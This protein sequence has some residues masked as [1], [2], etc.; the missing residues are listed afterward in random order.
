[1]ANVPTASRGPMDE[2]TL[3]SIVGR[4][5]RQAVDWLNGEIGADRETALDYYYGEPFGD[6]Q[7]GRSAVVSTDVQD[8]IE[9]IMPSMMEIFGGSQEVCSFDPRG[10]EDEEVASQA[11]AYVNYVW[12]S[13]NNGWS[14]IHDWIK[15]SL[16]QKNGVIK[17]YW[18]DTPE[19]KRETMVD[20][21]SLR[22]MELAEDDDIEILEVEQKQAPEELAMYIPDGLL[23]D[24][25]VK[26]LEQ[27]GRV[28]VEGLPPEEFLISRRTTDL[29][30]A[31]FLAHK[32]KKTRSDLLE[33]GFSR[34][35]VESIP[36]WDDHEYNEE[37]QARFGDEEF[38]DGEDTLDWASQEVWLYDCYMR[39]DHDGDGIT[40]MRN[41]L[42]A[43]SQY[44]I[45]SNEEVDEHPFCAITPVKMPHKFFGRS[46]ADLTVDIQK[47]KS[48][49][50]RQLLD[51]MYLTNNAR[52]GVSNKVDLDDFLTNRPGGGV[53]VD[54]DAPDV[55]GHIAPIVTQPLG[56]QALPL[57]DYWD[58][59]REV[60][61]GVTRYNQGMDAQALNKTASGINQI[62]GQAAKR[63]LLIARTFAETGFRP[64]M[65]KT[66]KLLVNHQDRERVI[67]LKNK[68]VPMDPRSWNADMDATINV[69]LGHGTKES[70]QVADQIILQLMEKVIQL[71]GGVQGPFVKPGNVHAVLKRVAVNNGYP[72]P[73]LVWSDPTDPENQPPPPQPN[74][75]VQIEQAKIQLEGQKAQMQMAL[76]RQETESRIEMERMKLGVSLQMKGAEMEQDRERFEAE[77]LIDAAESNAERTLSEE[78]AAA[79]ILQDREKLAAE[80]E[81]KAAEMK[82]DIQMEW[83]KL[84]A[85]LAIERAK[86]EGDL[87]KAQMNA[88][89]V[90]DV[91]VNLPGGSRKVQLNK[92]ENGQITGATVNDE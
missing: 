10:E 75:L 6:E 35:D 72:D 55:A 44:K 59:V 26:R 70:Q 42:V 58:N 9:S 22:M 81:M 78:K 15:D 89:T 74:P 23:Y 45:L 8:T 25:T 20:V 21:N 38:L 83:T 56:P 43:G 87:V 33:M 65:K 24:V 50:Q 60:R 13:M 4:E 49:I 64:A 86:L 11:T 66:L 48:A 73:N 18:D 40:E 63:Q 30:E 2:T 84:N 88:K 16:L 46:I 14:V 76:K 32:V 34:E 67:R 71:Q 19:Y 91:T 28:R 51:N 54:T 62:L 17:I 57:V 37:R 29:D 90:P 61:T 7:D 52:S 82:A 5:I 12:H 41:V 69:G 39:I 1:M 77:R 31:R 92:D 80:L 79:A 36:P 68:W 47:I 85:E 3:Q 27:N 53:R